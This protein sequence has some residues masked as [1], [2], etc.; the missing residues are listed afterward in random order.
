[1]GDEQDAAERVYRAASAADRLWPRR[2]HPAVGSLTAGFLGLASSIPT[3]NPRG[4]ARGSSLASGHSNAESPKIVD[5]HKTA[6]TS[7]LAPALA[8]SGDAIYLAWIGRDATGR[9]HIARSTD[10]LTFTKHIFD[11]YTS[12]RAPALAY[13]QGR[14]YLAYTAGNDRITMVEFDDPTTV[15]PT[16]VKELDQSTSYEPSLAPYG[17]Y[18]AVG[19]TGQDGANKLNVAGA[20]SQCHLRGL[21]LDR[22]VHRLPPDPAGPT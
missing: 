7:L 3:G 19:W 16:L 22:P 1:M 14:L 5:Q 4:P 10:G 18:V 2:K 9:I 20:G 11:A 21:R 17:R 13:N 12:T 15:V 6:N 8:S